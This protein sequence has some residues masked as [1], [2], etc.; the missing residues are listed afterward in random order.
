MKM[1]ETEKHHISSLFCTVLRFS[2][3]DS[4][5]EW[6]VPLMCNILD[7]EDVSSI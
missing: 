2:R 3:T 4:R 6:R 1:G 7:I 5:F